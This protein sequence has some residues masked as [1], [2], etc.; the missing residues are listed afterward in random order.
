MSRKMSAYGRK[1]KRQPQKQVFNGAEWINTIQRCRPY[2]DEVVPGAKQGKTIDAAIDAMR[3]V[4]GALDS[5]LAHKV[6]ADDTE[7]HNLLAHA[8][9]LTVIRSLQIAAD[10]DGVNQSE[11]ITKAAHAALL[12]VRARWDR[13]GKWGVAGPERQALI[14]V[15]DAYE[16]ILLASSPEQ[17]QAAHELR[18]ESLRKQGAW[19]FP[20][21]TA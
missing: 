11:P 5:L 7:P 19:P 14:D 4:R 6:A 3:Q 16:T 18:L 1:M 2:T 20:P 17:M 9:G 15:V 13:L 10:G 12:S 21:P 8:I